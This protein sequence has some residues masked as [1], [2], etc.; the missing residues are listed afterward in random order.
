MRA[1]SLLCALLL[2]AGAIAGQVGQWVEIGRAAADGIV[3]LRFALK[4]QNVDVLVVCAPLICT[5]ST[6]LL[7]S[8]MFYCVFVHVC[9]ICFVFFLVMLIILPKLIFIFTGNFDGCLQPQVQELRYAL[10]ACFLL[11][12]RVLPL[13][14]SDRKRSKNISC[15]K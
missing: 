8:I 4:Q 9:M 13:D 10:R 12:V 14:E 5:C 1:A 15:G 7:R 3:P 6:F 2:V 11:C